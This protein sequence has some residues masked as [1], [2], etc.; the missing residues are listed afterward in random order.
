VPALPDVVEREL[1]I[2]ADAQR[3][4]HALV[5]DDLLGA[6]LDAEARIDPRPGGEVA[7]EFPGGDVRIGEVQ[8]AEHERV[9]R[10]RWHA[11]GADSDG[12]LGVETQVAIELTREGDSTRVRLRE[13]GFAAGGAQAVGF[14]AAAGWAWDV[15]LASLAL[16]TALVLV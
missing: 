14:A 5:D 8:E 12:P 1:V 13:S 10:W 3:V 6:W 4:W 16:A 2:A 11:E 7:V 15:L 9:L